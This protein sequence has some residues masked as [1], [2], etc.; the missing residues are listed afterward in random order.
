MEK[1]KVT[2]AMIENLKHSLKL[3]A[4]DEPIIV[5]FFDNAFWVLGSELATLRIWKQYN[6]KSFNPDTYQSWSKNLDSYYFKI[7]APNY[8]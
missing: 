8:Y 7:E 1:I 3:I 2:N 5:E 4:G 6:Q